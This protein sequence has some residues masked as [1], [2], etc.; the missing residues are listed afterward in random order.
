MQSPSL[1][2]FYHSYL[3]H[4]DTARFMGSVAERYDAGTLAA[5]AERGDCTE[6]RAAVLALGYLGDYSANAVMAKAL[7]DSDRGVRLAAESGIRHIWLA[8]GTVGQRQQLLMAE[9]YVNADQ[10]FEA[11][12]VAGRVCRQSPNFAEAWRIRG[13]AHFG[14]GRI[15]HAQRDFAQSLQVNPFQYQAAIGLGNCL[16]RALDPNGALRQFQLAL[17]LNPNLDLIRVHVAR[18]SRALEQF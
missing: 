3:Q 13:I 4:Q 7:R 6:R 8:A 1:I 11:A 10:F 16:M 9:R 17:F 12:A 15:R 14:L 18:L 5:L 2:R